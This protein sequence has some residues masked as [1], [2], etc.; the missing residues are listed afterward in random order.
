MRLLGFK[1]GVSS[2]H[3]LVDPALEQYV[4]RGRED[5]PDSPSP[6]VQCNTTS[7]RDLLMVTNGNMTVNLDILRHDISWAIEQLCS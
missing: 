1:Y 7:H 2:G 5:D 4:G 6:I 3:A